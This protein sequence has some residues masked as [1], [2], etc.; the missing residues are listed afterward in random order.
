MRELYD[1][2]LATTDRLARAVITVQDG[3]DEAAVIGA[4]T[5]T[6]PDRVFGYLQREMA[7]VIPEWG[8]TTKFDPLTEEMIINGITILPPANA[9]AMWSLTPGVEGAPIANWGHTEVG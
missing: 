1:A 5:I 4:T 9:Q 2:M 8:K 6:I 3:T 7:Q